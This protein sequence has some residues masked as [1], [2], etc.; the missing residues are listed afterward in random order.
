MTGDCA[1]KGTVFVRFVA[2]LRSGRGMPKVRTFGLRL[3]VGTY[4]VLMGLRPNSLTR[5]SIVKP[6]VVLF[7]ATNLW[8]SDL[9]RWTIAT[10]HNLFGHCSAIRATGHWAS[11]V[12]IR[13]GCFG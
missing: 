7:A 6:V 10:D 5:C 9:R 12:K 2:A 4:S 8:G 1:T 13:N 3:A 11:F